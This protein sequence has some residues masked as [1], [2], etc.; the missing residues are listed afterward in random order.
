MVTC[1]GVTKIG[2]LVVSWNHL[3]GN[4][5]LG[6]IGWIFFAPVPKF[7]IGALKWLVRA[8]PPP[9]SFG[10]NSDCKGCLL[11]PNPFFSK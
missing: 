6:F 8:S 2:S 5:N 3:G 10:I 1:L 7:G 4:Y 11:T 9:P